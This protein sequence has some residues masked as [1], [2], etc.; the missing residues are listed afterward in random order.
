VLADDEELDGVCQAVRYVD[1]QTNFELPHARQLLSVLQARPSGSRERFRMQ[2]HLGR[3]RE[4]RNL[5]DTLLERVLYLPNE[6]QLMEHEA[7]RPIRAG[8][9]F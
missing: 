5:E 7:M 8:W 2:L 4:M 1:Q 6:V 9:R 3:R